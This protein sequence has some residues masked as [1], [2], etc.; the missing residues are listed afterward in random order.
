MQRNAADRFDLPLRIPEAL[1]NNKHVEPNAGVDIAAFQVKPQISL[2]VQIRELAQALI[3]KIEAQ[4]ESLWND[5]NRDL[6]NQFGSTLSIRSTT[7]SFPFGRTS[8]H[9]DFFSR[10]W[11]K[12]WRT[13]LG[14]SIDR[15]N[16]GS[17]PRRKPPRVAETVVKN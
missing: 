6:P 8:S 1:A 17:F 16:C 9:S 2:I 14:F 5:C 15:G 3:A 4:I 7:A 10:T 12:P 13:L 11:T